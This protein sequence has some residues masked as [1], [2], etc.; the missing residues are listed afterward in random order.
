MHTQ[1]TLFLLGCLFGLSS[2][3]GAQPSDARPGSSAGMF[4]SFVG[5]GFYWYKRNPD[6]VVPKKPEEKKLVAPAPAAAPAQ[7]DVVPPMSTRWLRENM[8]KLLDKAIDDPTPE[9]VANYMYAQRVI[10]DKS[11]NFSTA[12]KQ[13]VSTDPFLDENNRV[14]FSQFAQV[15]QMRDITAA[16]K[17]ILDHLAGEVGLWVFVDTPDKCSAC[18]SYV[19]N[20]LVGNS[21]VDGLAVKHNFHFKKIYVNTPEGRLAAE[22]LNL[23]ITPTTVMVAPPD[24]YF[25]VSQGLMAQDQLIDRLVVT[26]R[27]Y[28][29]LPRDL[30]EKANPYER[31]I[32]QNSDLNDLASNQTPTEVMTQL[33][34]R[35]NGGQK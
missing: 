22:R 10:L 27:A 8:P 18:E 32:L 9:N 26:G 20:V 35:I 33:R 19:S 25:L 17:E 30:I 31:G 6:P 3:L 34:E 13:V 7:S 2:G 1:K 5:D 23:T 29:L 28:N 15:A 14:P 16:R 11:Q 12:V 4:D 24:K 21:G